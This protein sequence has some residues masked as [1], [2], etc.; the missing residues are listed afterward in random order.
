[1]Y[2]FREDKI[3]RSIKPKQ[4]SEQEWYIHDYSLMYKEDYCDK[5]LYFN[6]SGNNSK[7]IIWSPEIKVVSCKLFFDWSDTTY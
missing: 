5:N 7:P 3:E 4:R 6:V 1:M 2:G